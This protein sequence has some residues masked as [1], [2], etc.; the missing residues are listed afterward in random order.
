MAVRILPSVHTNPIWVTVDNKP[1]RASR[2][3]AEWCRK[4]VDVCW[5][6][7]AGR[8]REGDKAAARAGY[9]E[10]ARIYDQVL[11]ESQVD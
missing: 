2:R 4:A 7:K 5:N 9:D 1:L 10:A 11:A 6:A 3:S 8:I